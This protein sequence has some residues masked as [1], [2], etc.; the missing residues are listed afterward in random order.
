MQSVRNNSEG[1]YRCLKY[2]EDYF[3]PK[4]QYQDFGPMLTMEF[5]NTTAIAEM[6]LGAGAKYDY[7]FIYFN[8]CLLIQISTSS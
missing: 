6:V 7:Y 8:T 5:F 2:L 4:F 1:D 3:P